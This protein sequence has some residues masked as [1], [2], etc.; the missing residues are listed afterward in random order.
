MQD[1]NSL[2]TGEDKVKVLIDIATKHRISLEKQ[3]EQINKFRHLDKGTVSSVYLKPSL[4]RKRFKPYIV[5]VWVLY[6]RFENC[7][8]CCY[9]EH[10]LIKVHIGR[11]VY[12]VDCT[13]DQFQWAFPSHKLPKVYIGRTLPNWMLLNKPSK[14]VLNLCGWTDWVEKG[15]YANRFNYWGYLQEPKNIELW[16]RFK[17]IQLY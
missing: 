5:Q 13:M 10:S 16:S 2:K 12:Y 8:D 14:R 1:I 7:N 11:L 4:S 6:E 9:E 17:N 15:Q 3:S